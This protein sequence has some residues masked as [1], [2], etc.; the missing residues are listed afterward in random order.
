MEYLCQNKMLI[1]GPAASGTTYLIRLFNELG[2]DTGFNFEKL[3]EAGS[4]IKGLEYTRSPHTRKR[5]QRFR[6][7]DNLDVSPRVIKI[8][9]VR[10]KIFKETQSDG[11]EKVLY[12]GHNTIKEALDFGWQI[13]HVFITIRDPYNS[14]K[15]QSRQKRGKSK[16]TFI[17]NKLWKGSGLYDVLCAAL[18]N[19]IP[20]HILLFPKT[21]E[22]P[23]YL[24]KELKFILGEMTY[25]RF[26]ECFNKIADINK[27]HFK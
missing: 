9:I 2:F 27:V 14:S 19:E 18:E 13:D 11:I 10:R 16:E 21:V 25:E 7:K 1:T 23:K 15:G 26:L 3:S 6:K 12:D 4:L 17:I 22:N 20:Y 8:P 5:F 24:F